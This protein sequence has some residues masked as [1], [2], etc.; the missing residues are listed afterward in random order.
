VSTDVVNTTLVG[1]DASRI[2]VHRSISND[3]ERNSAGYGNIDVT[4]AVGNEMMDNVD[5]VQEGQY[6]GLK[7]TYGATGNSVHN[8]TVRA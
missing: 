6:G 4:D 3:I 7:M 5:L 2:S 1:N 8:N